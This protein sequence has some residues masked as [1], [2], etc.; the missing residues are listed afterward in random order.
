[1]KD[2]Y[3]FIAPYYN[4]LAKLV[5]GK[6]LKEAKTCFISY[7]K[8][9][10][11]LI[12][13]GGDGLDYQEIQS[14]LSGEYWELSSSM[15]ELAKE[16]LKKSRL[17]FYLGNFQRKKDI[18][19]DEVWFHFVLDTMSDEEI[20]GIL[21]EIKI[22]LKEKGKV[23][24]VDFFQPITSKQKFLHQIMILF[25]R[26]LTSHKRGNIPDYEIIL[27]KNGLVLEKEKDFLKG[28]VKAQIWAKNN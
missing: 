5:F 21:N 23:Y 27:T 25:F 1:M 4:Q 12:I 11:I 18:L 28:W 3:N 7:L 9:K 10:K 15:L 22:V 26:L 20:E 19:F 6:R 14:N 13:G 16:N 8:S 2:R 17:N 24:L